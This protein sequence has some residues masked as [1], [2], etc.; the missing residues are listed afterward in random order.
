MTIYLLQ[1]NNDVVNDTVGCRSGWMCTAHCSCSVISCSR[2][3]RPSSTTTTASSS[4]CLAG[5]EVA[6]RRKSNDADRFRQI[7]PS[8]WLAGKRQLLQP[9]HTGHSTSRNELTRTEWG[10]IDTP[11][12]VLCYLLSF[13]RA[14]RPH[15]SCQRQTARR[16]PRH[17]TGSFQLHLRV[18]RAICPDNT[19]YEISYLSA[20][21]WLL[22]VAVAIATNAICVA[23]AAA[24]RRL[25]RSLSIQTRPRLETWYMTL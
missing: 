14:Q 24:V 18:C 9:T 22:P 23:T 3:S 10:P 21:V 12:A 16:R 5:Q 17:H 19:A 4:Q 15:A 11:T 7:R 6:R 8:D 13:V 25:W 1:A 2:S 20:A